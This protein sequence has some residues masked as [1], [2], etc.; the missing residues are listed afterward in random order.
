MSSAALSSSATPPSLGGYYGQLSRSTGARVRPRMVDA[1]SAARSGY[2]IEQHVSTGGSART[3]S[4]KP[5]VIAERRPLQLSPDNT[6]HAV[7]D[8]PASPVMPQSVNTDEDN[9]QIQPMVLRPEHAEHAS[10]H[11]PKLTKKFYHT[12]PPAE[13]LKRMTYDEL[14]CLPL[15]TVEK[16]GSDD[17]IAGS[18]TWQNVDVTDVDL[19]E[20]V[21]IVNHTKDGKLHRYVEV[22][23][24]ID[25]A[26]KPKEGEKLNQTAEVTFYGVECKGAKHV[27]KTRK[28]IE[29]IQG[30]LISLQGNMLKFRVPHWSRYDLNDSDTEDEGDIMVNEKATPAVKTTRPSFGDDSDEDGSRDAPGDNAAKAEQQDDMDDMEDAQQ[31]PSV[32]QPTSAFSERGHAEWNDDS[33]LDVRGQ[34]NVDH[35]RQFSGIERPT[36]RNPVSAP[37][38]VQQYKYSTTDYGALA[39]VAESE[40][41]GAR[42]PA[43]GVASDVSGFAPPPL[44]MRPQWLPDP[45]P[46]PPRSQKTQSVAEHFHPAG[47][48]RTL[49]IF[50][51][52][53]NGLRVMNVKPNTHMSL[54]FGLTMGRSFRATFGA[55]GQLILPFKRQ[56]QDGSGSSIVWQPTI[57]P[58]TTVCAPSTLGNSFLG[59]LEAHRNLAV[60]E[61]PLAANPDGSFSKFRLPRAV[62]RRHGGDDRDN[63]DAEN[64]EYPQLVELMHRCISITQSAAQ[65]KSY[66]LESSEEVASSWSMGQMWRLSCALWGQEHVKATY[67]APLTLAVDAHAIE[68]VGDP[69]R[70]VENDRRRGMITKWFQRAVQGRSEASVL[71]NWRPAPASS[72]GR[73]VVDVLDLLS[74]GRIA[75]AA[76]KAATKA[77]SPR[78]AMVIAS[79]GSG[80][81]REAALLIKD[82]IENW[83][84]QDA[85]D[86][87][88]PAM[89]FLYAMLSGDLIRVQGKQAPAAH[90]SLDGW[91]SEDERKAF[92]E[93]LD[94]LRRLNLHLIFHQRP[95]DSLRAAFCDYSAAV[96]RA[97]AAPPLPM[98]QAT[99]PYDGSGGQESRCVLYHML[100]LYCGSDA[101]GHETSVVTQALSPLS[102]TSDN[103]DFRHSWQLAMLFDALKLY[104][105]VSRETQTA[106]AHGLASQL[107]AHGHWEWAVYVYLHLDDEAVRKIAVRDVLLRHAHEK[108]MFVV[109]GGRQ[110]LSRE[111]FLC[112][113]NDGNWGLGLPKDLL[114]EALAYWKPY[115]HFAPS[116]EGVCQPEEQARLLTAAG[117]TAEESRRILAEDLLAMRWVPRM[118]LEAAPFADQLGTLQNVLGSSDPSSTAYVRAYKEYLEVRTAGLKSG[119]STAMDGTPLARLE[120][121][122]A[123][124]ARGRVFEGSGRCSSETYVATHVSAQEQEEIVRQELMDSVLKL[125]AALT[126]AVAGAEGF[127]EPHD[128]GLA[129]VEARREESARRL[130]LV[131]ATKAFVQAL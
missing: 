37:Q 12:T 114:H 84:R 57:L 88:D 82:Q 86:S 22:Y 4:R 94:W 41:N 130:W 25:P 8:V 91:L 78:L 107:I 18:I 123:Q 125:K 131:D 44:P 9:L 50:E 48:S 76:R 43:G 63:E 66:I 15:F 40:P 45:Q 28:K 5:L 92:S 69:G 95:F 100:S 124:F 60:V 65:N 53:V 31:A 51:E 19:D 113:S 81:G 35:Q 52:A 46:I 74:E 85:R 77:A 104:A 80:A 47:R 127:P 112:G 1:T 75:E 83:I 21:K 99:A 16:Y 42:P 121:V 3:S 89:R 97:E 17:E 23:E 26:S 20:H 7:R 72:V 128:A 71:Q 98:Y 96:R 129:E 33:L 126:D 105:P 64:S 2:N 118:T 34:R 27:E 13:E 102:V 30:E 103:L 67:E 117:K 61:A 6:I 49:Q 106:I 119:A 68:V 54:D 93:N 120:T 24:G 59:V 90:Q 36:L 79:V 32:A 29:S 70:H 111:E 55:N 39:L 56:S 11:A 109:D 108:E 115:E 87:I 10:T 110:Q 73:S 38:N 58:A 62:S 116:G 122:C 14:R 101:S